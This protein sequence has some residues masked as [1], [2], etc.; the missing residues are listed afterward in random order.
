MSGE[1]LAS[2]AIV[3]KHLYFSE[4]RCFVESVRCFHHICFC[5]HQ[6]CLLHM[7]RLIS[8]R[9]AWITPVKLSGQI[10]CPH[11]LHRATLKQDFSST[12]LL[13]G[14]IF[15]RRRSHQWI[16]QEPVLSAPVLRFVRA[17]SAPCLMSV[18]DCPCN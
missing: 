4:K 8:F 13:W 17:L 14:R 15:K 9:L 3:I 6:S 10:F 2:C 5:F 11:S 1:T 18:Q 7:R 12:S 16:L